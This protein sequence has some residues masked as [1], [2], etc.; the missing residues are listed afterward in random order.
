MEKRR[1]GNLFNIN[2][3]L[4]NKASVQ[5]KIFL[6]FM[7]FGLASAILISSALAIGS[8]P[9]ITLILPN[10]QTIEAGDAY[11][12]LGATAL[13][14]EDGDLTSAI[15][16]DAS[17][18]DTATVGSYSVTYDVQDSDLN[19]AVQ[20]IRTVDVVDTTAPTIDA[21]LD[22]TG[23]EATSSAGADVTITPPMSH[24][25]VDGDL[26]S[27]CD[28]STGTFPLG[29]TL[30]TCSKTDA[31][32]NVA[33]DSTFNVIV[34]DTT[35]P[36]IDAMSDI[37]GVEATDASGAVVTYIDPATNDLV[38]VPGTASCAPVS[39]STFALGNTLVTCTATDSNGNSAIP[40]T[41]NV[42]VVD[43]TPP[44][45]SLLGSDPVTIEVGSSYTDDGATASDIYDGDITSSIVIV[46]PVDINTVGSYTITYDVDDS[47]GNSA[48]QVTRT[49][50]VVD[51]T[52]PVITLLGSNPQTI[53]VGHAYVELGAT[54]LD[55]YDGD[56][57]A[58]IIIDSSSVNTNSI[59]PY[60]VTYDVTDANGNVAIQV[61]R[62]VEIVANS[63]SGSGGSPALPLPITV[64]LD[65]RNLEKQTLI[66]GD[67]AKF[68]I[69]G[70]SHAAKIIALSS[71]SVTIQISSTPF[72]VAIN[73]GETKNVDV[74][75]D[76]IADL[77][78][79]LDNV[80]LGKASLTFNNLV[81]PESNVAQPNTQSQINTPTESITGNLIM[82]SVSGGKLVPIMSMIVLS[83][84]VVVA[85]AYLT[86]RKRI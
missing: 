77:S 86:Y 55:N 8:D 22:I 29:T 12:E 48:T 5:M 71:T 24:D 15:V 37:I 57:T 64:T 20:V 56:I 82:P 74:N 85:I 68:T 41:F 26:T 54:A 14:A 50:D 2:S 81:Q 7:I 60:I 21:V 31:N 33:T 11:T 17:L 23:V 70:E 83:S 58:S 3:R 79:T 62:T 6:S 42:N 72:I 13:D 78:I 28:Y 30:V 76:G 53:V 27:S 1:L 40:V 84:L 73:L 43:T 19:S 16:I 35:P 75:S 44:V 18:V 10:P 59:G 52:P 61:T 25:Y 32:G 66:V 63:V 9:V 46:N 4:N 36:V 51:T 38:D 45:I 80:E 49:V 47:N 39:G 65:L 67:T 69:N 34:Q